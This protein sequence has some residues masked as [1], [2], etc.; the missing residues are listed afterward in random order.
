MGRRTRGG[1][2]EERKRE[3][4]GKESSKLILKSSGQRKKRRPLQELHT[5]PPVSLPDTPYSEPHSFWSLSVRLLWTYEH[6][7]KITIESLPTDCYWTSKLLINSGRKTRLSADRSLSEDRENQTINR[8]ES[9]R[10]WRKVFLQEFSQGEQGKD[11]FH[12]RV[13]NLQLT[14]LSNATE[15]NFL[16]HRK[17]SLL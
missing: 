9:I 8:E 7:P 11:H 16:P 12:L 14:L 15:F 17:H 3:G 5:L 13:E 2:G 10:R 6:Y 1:K 4:V